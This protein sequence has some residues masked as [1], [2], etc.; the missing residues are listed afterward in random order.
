VKESKDAHK[1]IEEFM[2]LANKAVAEYVSKIK[3]NKEP[4]PF[5]YRIHATPDEEK[6][7]PF[8]AFA[9]KF[10]YKFN[11]QDEKQV[12][13]SF[14]NLM[15]EIKGKPEQHVL[16]QL[17]IRTMAKAVYT[18]NNIGHYG[19]GFEN[20]CHFTSPIRR[21]PDIMVHRVLQ[22]CLEKNL[23]LDKKMEQSCKHCSDKERSAMEAER[24]GNKYKQVEFMKQFLGDDF[25]G[26][27][28]GVSSFGF[29]VETVEHKCEGL[30]SI[31]DLNQL[32]DFRLIEAEYCL[33]GMRTKTT[34]RMGDKIKIKIVAANLTKRQLDYEWVNETEM[35]G[36][37]KKG[38]K[39]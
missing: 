6:L 1:L 36:K 5:P 14:N 3:V 7:K 37:K 31:K 35:A 21:Y 16:E 28:S 39:G 29:W 18:S 15:K 30:V 8:S 2:L 9:K 10:G 26:V 25:D 20:Y 13:L 23:K 11:M 32:D 17:G 4:I 19:L 33:V 12:A 38:K 24:A 27:I 34:F 22:E